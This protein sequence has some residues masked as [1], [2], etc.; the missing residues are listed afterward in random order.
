MLSLKSWNQNNPTENA[1]HWLSS[2]PGELD[3]VQIFKT[4]IGKKLLGRG[5]RNGKALPPRT[6]P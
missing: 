1:Y 6:R 2:G 3:Q 5:A 4:S